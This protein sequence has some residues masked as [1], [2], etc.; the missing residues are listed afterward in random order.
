MRKANDVKLD[1]AAINPESLTG[2]YRKAYDALRKCFEATKKAKL[3]FEAMT[4]LAVKGA[5]YPDDVSYAAIRKVQ[6]LLNAGNE[7]RFSYLR[8]IAVAAAPAST[9]TKGDRN[10]VSLTIA[11]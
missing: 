4:V 6:T 1:W 11:A 2:D 9:A 8:G 10:G 3:A 5:T 7:A